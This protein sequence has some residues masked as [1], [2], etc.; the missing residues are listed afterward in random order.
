[1]GPNAV[2]NAAAHGLSELALTTDEDLIDLERYLAES[3][4]AEGESSLRADELAEEW[5][6]RMNEAAEASL[7]KWSAIG[8]PPPAVQFREARFLTLRHPR[9]P[10]LAPLGGLPADYPAWLGLVDGAGPKQ[11]TLMVCAWLSA[12][13]C[14][15]IYVTDAAN[16]FGVDCFGVIRE[17]PLRSACVLG[18]AKT[19]GKAISVATVSADYNRYSEGFWDSDLAGRCLHATQLEDS[20]GGL[21]ATY[22]FLSNSEFATPCR[23][24]ARSHRFLL[25]D[26]RQLAYTLSCAFTFDGLA[27]LLVAR[28]SDV[29]RSLDLN[30]APVF[31]ELRAS[32]A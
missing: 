3:F 7:H 17:G 19:A 23:A 5:A 30:W 8:V 16:D 24:F 13:G 20:A 32:S 15:E 12:A 31:E 29:R 10:A 26:R 18:Q 22:V 4:E 6:N 14:S 2:V 28:A 27:T 1:M 21:A 11:F 9:Y 25:R